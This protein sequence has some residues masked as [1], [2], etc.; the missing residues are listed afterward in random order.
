MSE[1]IQN[2]RQSHKFHLESHEKLE[3]GINNGKKNFSR[4]KNPA[5]LLPGRCVFAN[6]IC[7]MPLHCTG[8]YKFTKSK[9]K[10]NHLMYMDDIKLFA[11]NEK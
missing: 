9:D 11:K 3:S 4:D 6:I 5:R 8:S 1:N 7:N 10:I 2:I